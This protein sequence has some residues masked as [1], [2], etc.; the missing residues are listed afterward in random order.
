MFVTLAKHNTHT[1]THW[2]ENWA[3]RVRVMPCVAGGIKALEMSVTQ[4]RD[5]VV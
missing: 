3:D 1:R 2:S 4:A 5:N